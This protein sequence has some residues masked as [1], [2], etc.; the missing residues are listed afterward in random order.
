MFHKFPALAITQ[1]R[2][3][4]VLHNLMLI[5]N[6]SDEVVTFDIIP[7]IF[8]A[9]SA[10]TFSPV[11][12]TIIGPLSFRGPPRKSNMAWSC[13]SNRHGNVLTNRRRTRCSDE[14]AIGRVMAL[15]GGPGTAP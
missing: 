15:F 10:R 14:R 6:I 7:S 13:Q 1:P 2:S 9:A 11:Y 12:R 4:F 5:K 3:E 8:I